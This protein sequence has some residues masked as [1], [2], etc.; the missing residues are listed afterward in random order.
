MVAAL[1]RKRMTLP[2]DFPAEVKFNTMKYF[3]VIV[4]GRIK[5]S[6]INPDT[7]R[8]FA[9]LLLGPGDVF[10]VICLVDDQEHLVQIDIL[11]DVQILYI[12]MREVRFWIQNHADFNKTLC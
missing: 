9:F 6:Q 4:S 12:F 11:E 7:G 10:D 8:E 5:I 1:S 2:K 3:Y